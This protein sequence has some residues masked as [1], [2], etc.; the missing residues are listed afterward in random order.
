MRNGSG[1]FYYSNGSK[2]EGEWVDNLKEGFAI[3]TYEDGRTFIGSY[4]NDKIVPNSNKDF[5]ADN[6]EL[7]ITRNA[8]QD[9]SLLKKPAV[10]AAAST[11]GGVGENSPSKRGTKK[12]QATTLTFEKPEVKEPLRGSEVDNNPYD[13]MLDISDLFTDEDEEQA[14]IQIKEV[15][16]LLLRYNSGL[17]QL[18]RFYTG[19]QLTNSEESFSLTMKMFWKMLRDA[20]VLSPKVTIAS[21]DRLFVQGAKNTFT[22]QTTQQALRKNLY[23]AKSKPKYWMTN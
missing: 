12:L 10:A 4:K 21:F 11:N 8:L 5:R 22:L 9:D 14:Y 15:K 1:V 16:N 3:F 20:K 13:A 17:K 19:K 23:L 2:Y 18:Y 6:S 7:N